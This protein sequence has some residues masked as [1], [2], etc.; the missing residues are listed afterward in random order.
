MSNARRAALVLASLAALAL[1]SLPAAAQVDDEVISGLQ[2]NFTPPGAR[3]LGLGGAFLAVANDAT[4]AYTNPAGLTNLTQREVL[5]EGRHFSTSTL[6]SEGGR[7]NGTPTGFGVDTGGGLILGESDDEVASL[8]FVSYVQPIGDF[9]LA[10]YRHQLVDFESSFRSRGVFF[11][12][13]GD[14]TSPSFEGCTR[15]F[16]IET[17]LE[18]D[19]EN[20]GAAFA[21][22]F[23][24]SF[25]F[26]I[27]LNFYGFD[28][29]SSTFRFDFSNPDFEGPGGF[30]GAPQYAGNNVFATQVQ[31]GSDDQF[32]INVGFLWEA[33]QYFSLGGV[34]REGA[35][36]DYEYTLACGP[37]DPAFCRTVP[38]LETGVRVVD[39]TFGLPSVWGVGIAIRPI[40]TFTITVDY[41]NVEYSALVD[42]F[43]VA[44]VPDALPSEFEV[45]DAD[46]IHLGLEYVFAQ[47]RN[48][49][50]IRA[51][52]WED[53][54]HQ[55]RY[56][57][58]VPTT[59]IA[60][61]AGSQ[62][63]DDETHLSFGLGFTIGENFSIDVAGDFSERYDTAALSAVYRF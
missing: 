50:T 33:S 30:F 44:A 51:G 28:I 40:A 25:S 62:A 9:R 18:L 1:A 14:C 39:A 21:Y 10:L 56:E 5:L 2:F 27:G 16:P 58:N 13:D 34:Y 15:L 23:G 41:D 47:L 35:D 54:A 59:T 29:E 3:S 11:N 57:G 7:F 26:G 36:F 61:W 32:G 43:R 19:I 42:N 63:A 12:E 31:S 4:A 8:S 24:D 60:L 53:P 46:E 52:A 37:S 17:A 38:G 55:I 22:Q 49:I 48:P 20:F 45:D 6:F